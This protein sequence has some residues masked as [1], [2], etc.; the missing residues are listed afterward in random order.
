[1][2]Q[3]VRQDWL[4]LQS[5]TGKTVQK[6]ARRMEPTK[7]TVTVC[8]T[9]ISHSSPNL[10][11]PLSSLAHVTWLLV[12]GRDNCSQKNVQT[13]C[14]NVRQACLL[15]QILAGG[16]DSISNDCAKKRLKPTERRVAV[17]KTS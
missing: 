2:R 3:N 16:H 7:G 15:L 5:I 1:M 9:N 17:C 13:I 4:Q 14:Q 12:A 11:A 6:S 10:Y 8:T